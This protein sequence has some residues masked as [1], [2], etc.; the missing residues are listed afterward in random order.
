MN[1]FEIRAEML[2]MAQD[3]LEK[4]HQINTEFAKQVFDQL[5]VTGQK[6]Q[7]D[8][9]TYA[10]KMYDFSEVVEKAKQLYGFVNAK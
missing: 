3:Y 1:P 6:V 7:G 2:K 10:P 4:Q 9:Q 5:V 8:W